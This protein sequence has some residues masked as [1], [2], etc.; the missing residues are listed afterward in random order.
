MQARLLQEFDAVRWHEA[1]VV[2]L[3]VALAAP[4]SESLLIGLGVSALGLILRLWVNGY[5]WGREEFVVC[6]PYRF[7]RHPYHLGTFLIFLGICLA[8]RSFIATA[9]MLCGT[10]PIFRA[11]FREE[12]GLQ[13]QWGGMRFKEYRMQVSAFLPNVVPYPSFNATGLRFSTRTA[14]FAQERREL[15]TFVSLGVGYAVLYGL[16]AY[17]QPALV[18]TGLAVVIF[19]AFIFQTLY[20]RFKRAPLAARS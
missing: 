1:L 17:P 20:R 7:V 12:E 14:L 15:A 3:V 9:G 13:A 19:S 18:Q 16:W 6:G 5:R 11:I 4:T 2:V 8:S 10:V